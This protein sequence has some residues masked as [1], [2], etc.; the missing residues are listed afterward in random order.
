MTHRQILKQWLSEIKLNKQ[1][2]ID[3]GSG[4]KPA[5][6]YIQSKNC[7]FTTLDSADGIPTDRK[8]DEHIKCD[9]T[10]FRDFGQF[11][12]AFCLEVIEHVK[13]PDELLTNIR[14]NIKTG[15]K[16]YFSAPFKYPIHGESDYWRYTLDGVKLLLSQHSFKV[17][18]I[19]DTIDELGY[20]V[21]AEAI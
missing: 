12:A 6:R 10:E 15:G 21:E 17:L 13:L 9:I 20:L 4:S 7:S 2:V 1:Y 8:G 11:D 18:S 3:W 16:L 14:Q 19:K 5:F